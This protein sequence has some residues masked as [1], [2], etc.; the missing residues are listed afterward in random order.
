VVAYAPEWIAI[1]ATLKAPGYLILSD[2]WYPG[3]QATV[4]GE[5]ATIERANTMFR[6]IYLPAGQHEVNLN[7]RP[8]SLRAGIVISAIAL[9]GLVAAAAWTRRSQQAKRRDPASANQSRP[10]GPKK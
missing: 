6:A 7:Y 8:A 5:Q 2:A 3:W 1:E 10:N 4:D 9:L